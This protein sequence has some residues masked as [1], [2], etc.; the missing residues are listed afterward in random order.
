MSNAR[1]NGK[2]SA[3]TKSFALTAKIDVVGLVRA[4]LSATIT[5]RMLVLAISFTQKCTM[6]SFKYLALSCYRRRWRQHRHRRESS[7]RTCKYHWCYLP[8][9][10]YIGAYFKNGKRKYGASE[11]PK[12]NRLHLLGFMR[13]AHRYTRAF[14]SC[15]ILLNVNG[16]EPEKINWIGMWPQENN[17]GNYQHFVVSC[18]GKWRGRGG[19][20]ERWHYV[21]FTKVASAVL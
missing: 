21:P 12:A 5:C 20:R 11:N 3:T 17:N 18:G 19:G 14:S 15:R 16:C 6:L 2:K 8:S 1:H 9:A 10:S 13:N 7:R 4:R